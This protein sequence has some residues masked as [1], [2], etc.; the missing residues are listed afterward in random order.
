MVVVLGVSFRAGTE[1]A[2]E[3]GS[4]EGREKPKGY[5]W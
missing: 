2:R 4:W 5:W 3:F 1:F